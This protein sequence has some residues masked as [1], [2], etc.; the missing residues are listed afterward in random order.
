MYTISDD[1]MRVLEGVK[2]RVRIYVLMSR[3]ASQPVDAMDVRN[4]MDNVQTANSKISVE[5]VSPDE[6][7]AVKAV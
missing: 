3:Y 6:A 7:V 2:D 1:A 5:Y 4:L